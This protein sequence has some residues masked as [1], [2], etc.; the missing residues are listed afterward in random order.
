MRNYIR[1]LKIP[2]KSGKKI[3]LFR[4]LCSIIGGLIVTLLAMALL[5]T[6]VPIGKED[7]TLATIIIDGSIWALIAF[8][9][10][11]SSS[12]YIALLR[13]LIP[14]LILAIALIILFNI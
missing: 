7:I 5:V 2:E 13:C 6:I 14:S 10:S 8:W 4:I 12:K 9:I 11:L 3:G 1:N